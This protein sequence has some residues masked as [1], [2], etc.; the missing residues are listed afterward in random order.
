M[1]PAIAVVDDQVTNLKVL[2]RFVRSLASDADIRLFSRAADALAHFERS[3]PDL[4]FTDFVMPEIDGADFVRRL[5]RMEGCADVPV[6]IVTAYED[7]ALRY[8]ALEAGAT[9]Y[10]LSPIDEAE[11]CARAR[12]LLTMRR[13]QQLLKVHTALL[14]KRIVDEAQRHKVEL[15][16]SHERLLQVIDAVPAAISATD[17]EG[18]F[19]FVNRHFCA[20][21]ALSVA[22][23]I[24]AKPA[25]IL[26]A[27]F[28]DAWS[29]GD[30]L[31]RERKAPLTAEEVFPQPGNDPRHVLIERNLLASPSGDDL[32]VTVVVDISDRKRVEQLLRFA[33]DMAEA[34]DRTKTEFL[35]NMSHELRTPLNAVIG[36]S[37]LLLKEISGASVRSEALDY[38]GEIL[39]SGKLLLGVVNDVLDLSK[40]E[41]GVVALNEESVDLP[42]LAETVLQLMRGWPPATAIQV[43]LECEPDLPA[44]RADPQRLKQILL[45]LLSN[46]VKFS[47]PGGQVVVRA[48]LQNGSIVLRVEDQGIGMSE[49]EVAV[50]VSRFGQV[51]SPWTRTQPGTGLGLPIA[52]KLIE[53]HDGHLAI[54]SRKGEGTTITVRFPPERTLVGAGAT[55]LSVPTA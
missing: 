2:E 25:D 22:A 36:F 1:H 55:R 32:V 10:L 44:L 28:A 39:S 52:I 37:E 20:S 35:A 41:A 9:D 29:A 48:A 24:G 33:K 27:E 50:A 17:A 23:V 43:T 42:R 53:L 21:F 45:N 7:R 31:V 26:P 54:G 19:V 13:Q 4:V 49:D 38:V 18:R 12:N 5:R 30:R 8:E 34:A 40:I 15:R 46:A 3:P 14:E 6:I 16:S 11:F 51:E 47:P